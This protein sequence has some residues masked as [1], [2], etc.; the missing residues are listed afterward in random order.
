M[1]EFVSMA[2]A[3]GRR[4]RIGRDGKGWLT[5]LNGRSGRGT[6]SSRP[7]RRCTFHHKGASAHQGNVEFLKLDDIPTRVKVS[8]NGR[9]LGHKGGSNS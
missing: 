9:N 7:S 8:N 3:C 6:L 5:G 2:L 1:C 4:T